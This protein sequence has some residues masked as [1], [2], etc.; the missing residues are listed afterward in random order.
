MPT[1]GPYFTAQA[2]LLPVFILALLA[3]TQE[4]QRI[5]EAWFQKVCKEPIRSV[6]DHSCSR[7]T[8]WNTHFFAQAVQSYHP[9]APLR[10]LMTSPQT[11][12]STYSSVR[13]IRGWIDRI[14]MLP[15]NPTNL[16]DSIAKRDPWW[17]RLVTA[18]GEIEENT[19]CL[20]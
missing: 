6:S 11:L 5:A 14:L 12:H 1:S 7:V 13:R 2:P 4:H 19:L 20:G 17:E 3:T 15:P 9:P 8:P 16:P 18:I 10:V